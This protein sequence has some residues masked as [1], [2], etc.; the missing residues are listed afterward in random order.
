MHSSTGICGF[1]TSAR[2][3]LLFR[4]PA[5]TEDAAKRELVDR[6][7]IEFDPGVVKVFLS[8]EGIPELESFAKVHEDEPAADAVEKKS[9]AWDLFSSFSK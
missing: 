7:G 9:R 8:L 4:V 6:A 1:P 5:L 3:A 2:S